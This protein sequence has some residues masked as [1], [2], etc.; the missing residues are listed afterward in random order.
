[1]RYM[2]DTN[3][4]AYARNDRPQSVLKRLMQHSPEDYCISAITLA[5][6]EYGVYNSTRPE[7]NQLALMTFLARIEVVP[8]G[9]DAAREYGDIRADL[10]RKGALIGANDLLIAA[11]A[12]ALDL[13]LVTN[14]TLEFERVEGLKL[15][16]L[17]DR[18][19]VTHF[20]V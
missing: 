2:L 13:T 14:N 1:M 15:E 6:L 19:Q 9:P 8:F 3:I 10:K 7:Q 12:R 4:I 20:C 18:F 16:S 11:H 5:E 17:G